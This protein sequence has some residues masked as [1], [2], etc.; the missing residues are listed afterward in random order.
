MSAG[1]GVFMATRS[2]GTGTG[3]ETKALQKCQTRLT[4]RQAALLP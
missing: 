2:G 4:H 3:Q 1:A